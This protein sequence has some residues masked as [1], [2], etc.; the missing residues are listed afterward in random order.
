MQSKNSAFG[1]PVPVVNGSSLRLLRLDP[2]WL[3]ACMALDRRALD[4][5]WSEAQW[6][7]ELTEPGRLCVGLVNGAELLGFA[8]GWLVIDELHITALAVDPQHRQ[9]GCGGRLLR[10]LLQQAH[11]QGARQATLEVAADNAAALALYAA[12]GF[13]TTGR[14]SRYYSDGRDALIQWLELPS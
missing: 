8:C 1:C 5:F 14:R 13:T 2:S 7:R 3:A 9:F 10:A 11:Q 6:Q 4:G 12:E